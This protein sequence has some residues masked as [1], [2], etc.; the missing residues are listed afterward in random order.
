MADYIQALRPYV[1]IALMIAGAI[2]LAF[3]AANWA[4][5]AWHERSTM[6]TPQA[7]VQISI[8]P[9]DKVVPKAVETA[10]FALG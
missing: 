10:T 8:P 7:T 1:R 2:V 5:R 6:E 4:T 9:M 3:F